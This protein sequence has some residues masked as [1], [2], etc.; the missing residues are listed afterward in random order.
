M[1]MEMFE[2][3]GK[4]IYELSDKIIDN[5]HIGS[6]TRSNARQSVKGEHT[7]VTGIV[8]KGQKILT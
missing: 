1:K 6:E 5:F 2:T 3:K 4:Y 8:L 7:T